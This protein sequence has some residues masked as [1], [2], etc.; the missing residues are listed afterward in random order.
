MRVQIT[1]DCI[2]DNVNHAKGETAE[3]ATFWPACMKMLGDAP[4][5]TP[6]Q[7]TKLATPKVA[8]PVEPEPKAPEETSKPVAPSEPTP[9]VGEGQPAPVAPT[10]KKGGKK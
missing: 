3:V 10:T 2:I 6:V 8:E 4:A 1:S 5:E 7:K 9:A